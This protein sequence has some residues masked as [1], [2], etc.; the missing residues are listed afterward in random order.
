MKLTF[1]SLSR[2]EAFARATVA[3]FVVQMDPTM[4]ELNEIKTVVSEAVTNAIIHGYEQSD[5]EEITIVCKIKNEQE[6]TIKIIDNGVGID[7]ITMAKE[8]LYTSKPELERSGMG[9]SIMENFMDSLSIEST[10]GLGTTVTMR[11]QL[12][13]A[14][15]FC[16]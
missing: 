14:K 3:A 5:N 8:P 6:L 12:M 4:D 11:K 2:N 10:V 7:N 13:K 9:F 1:M 16:H 15:S